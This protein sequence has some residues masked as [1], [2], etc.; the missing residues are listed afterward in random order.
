MEKQFKHAIV[1][2]PG[3]SM[4]RGLTTAN[5]G[6][7][8]HTLALKQHD[9]YIRAL[10]DC[11]LEVTVLEAL[12]AYPDA[13]FVE[14]VALCTRSCAVLTRPGAE[15]RL[16][17]VEYMRSVLRERYDNLEK[18][19]EPGTLDAGDVLMVGDHYYVGMSGR[20]NREGFEQLK[21]IL[22]R[23]GMSAEAV[24]PEEMLH[25]KTGAAYLEDNTMLLWES[26][27]EER[28]F[29]RFR[30]ILV[31]SDEAYAANCI[32]VNDKVLLAS[33]Y[34]VTRGRLHDAGFDLIALDM[35]EYRKLDGGLSCL[36]L[37]F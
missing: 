29:G 20:T 17:E 26:L 25:L 36:S 11:G 16:G 12:E 4:V 33:G 37:R 15:S 5:A 14:D 31:E 28:P 24:Q 2:R 18:I 9:A 23:Y 32:R 35:S 21:K 13:V 22:R 3:E 6:L 30:K 27:A 10:A 19:R 34:P 8:D 1:R 7:P